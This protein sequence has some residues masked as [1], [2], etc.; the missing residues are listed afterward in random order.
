MRKASGSLDRVHEN[1]ER[2]GKRGLKLDQEYVQFI[3]L[4]RRRG[5]WLWYTD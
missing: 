5:L 1:S 3:H 2:I 4:K